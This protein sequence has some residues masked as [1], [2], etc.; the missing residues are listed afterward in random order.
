[1][2]KEY[3]ERLKDNRGYS[4]NTIKNY[5]RTI[6]LFDRYLKSITFKKWGADNCEN[7]KIHH[8]ETFIQKQRLQNKDALTCN[9]YLACIKCY[10][11]FCLLCDK[12]VLNYT[13]LTFARVQKKKIDSS[14]DDDIQKLFNYFRN[15]EPDDKFWEM[16][17]YRN[18]V[19]MQLLIYT[20]L[21]VSELSNI[22]I[23]D[24][25]EDL[26]IIWKGGKRRVVNLYKDDIDL[27]NLYLF[28]RRKIDSEY[29]IISFSKNSWGKKLSNA[30]I[31]KIIRDA[32]VNAGLTEKVYPHKLRHT[33]ATN[34]L[35]C[36]ASIYH[37]KELLGHSSIATTQLYL[38]ASNQELRETQ[39]KAR[40]Y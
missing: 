14:T 37:I 5:T 21:R 31:E 12:D 11:H 6:N 2:I 32:G 15:Q 10:L 23:S 9:N 16:V 24:I 18:L 39:K 35:R 19:I 40:K 8:V 22:K 26:Q 33:F 7:I 36:G 17:K 29:L 4:I 25:G 3:I 1:M 28:M 27:I 13:K 34:L 20:G 38:S 30:S